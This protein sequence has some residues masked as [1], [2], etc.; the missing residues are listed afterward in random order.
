MPY[1]LKESVIAGVGVF[2]SKSFDFDEFIGFF[3]GMEVQD[4]SKKCICV[5]RDLWIEPD[6]DEPLRHLNH[7]C[8][9]NAYFRGQDLHARGHIAMGEEIT[10]NYNCTEPTVVE[11]IVCR[12]PW[13][14]E[15]RII[16]G[17]YSWAPNERQEELAFVAE[18]LKSPIL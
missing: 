6:A 13:H 1:V 16:R 9:A 4:G 15:P 8:K 12:C 10:I 2:A 17:F 11:P 14:D 5:A 3:S 18:W 7:C